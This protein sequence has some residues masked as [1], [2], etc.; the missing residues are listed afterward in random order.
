MYQR[1]DD[2]TEGNR[3]KTISNCQTKLFKIYVILYSALVDI[4]IIVIIR[5]SSHWLLQFLRMVLC[6][7]SGSLFCH[8]FYTLTPFYFLL[9]V[10]SFISSNRHL[11][12]DLIKSH[13]SQAFLYN[14][15]QGFEFL[16]PKHSLCFTPSRA[17][18]RSLHYYQTFWSFIFLVFV[19]SVDRPY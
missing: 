8:S 16:S 2:Q 13:I 7:F 5:I 14:F 4:N 9:L 1:V 11:W 15:S 19:Y 10:N 3:S 17:Y 6:Y 18:F 12:S